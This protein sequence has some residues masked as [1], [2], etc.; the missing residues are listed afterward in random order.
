[1]EDIKEKS[2]ECEYC[3]NGKGICIDN[4]RELGIELHSAK[5]KLVAYGLDKNNWDISVE[6]NIKYCP[7]CRQKVGIDMAKITQT[8]NSIE[9]V[10]ENKKEKSV[11]LQTT[12]EDGRM[13]IKHS[14][15]NKKTGEEIIKEFIFGQK[16]GVDMRKVLGL[17]FYFFGIL[18]LFTDLPKF[19]AIET[20][21]IGYLLLEERSQIC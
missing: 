9:S 13:K 17:I 21:V 8:S 19:Q 18:S 10:I 7:M 2:A 6:C 16:V 5:S 15:L 3:K 11:L 20:I 12:L 4:K 14:H 1:M